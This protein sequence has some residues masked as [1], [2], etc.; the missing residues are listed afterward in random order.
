MAERGVGPLHVS[1]RRQRVERF[2]GGLRPGRSCDLVRPGGKAG[3]LVAGLSGQQ[4]V[5][6][7]YLDADFAQRGRQGRGGLGQPG[8]RALHRCEQV[9]SL[10]GGGFGGLQRCRYRPIAGSQPRSGVGDNS[11]GIFQ[12]FGCLIRVRADGVDGPRRIPCGETGE[13]LAGRGDPGCLLGNVSVHLGQQL[14]HPRREILQPVERLR[15][16]IKRSARLQAADSD[17][18]EA[19]PLRRAAF[20]AV[21]IL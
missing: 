6:I 21:L 4:S 19:G 2:G 15:V 16:V 12:P 8:G 10:I 3:P 7:G 17:L 5:S 13:Y 11:R 20:L 9:S 18:A 14:R 1:Q